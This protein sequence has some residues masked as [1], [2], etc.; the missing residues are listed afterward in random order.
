M[1]HALPQTRDVIPASIEV[2]PRQAVRSTELPGLFPPRT[3]TYLTDVGVDSVKDFVAAT[4]RIADLG[5]VPVPH[6]PARRIRSR[7]ELQTRIRAYAEEAGV[8]DVLVI[9]GGLDRPAGPY[10]SSMEILESGLLDRHGISEI[11]VAGHPEGSPEFSLATAEAALRLKRDFC[12][13]TG[14][15]MRIVTQFGFDADAYVDWAMAVRESGIGL[16]I[17]IGVAGP[18][19]ITTLIRYAALCGVGSSVTFLKK[20]TGALA[21]LAAHHSPESVVGPIEQHWRQTPESPIRQIHV[22]PFGGL[23]QSATW[24]R[25]R[26]SW[27][28]SVAERA[29]G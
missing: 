2:A 9:G 3:R 6:I 26:G 27:P 10:T 13:R 4:R 22:F 16:P 11:G 23:A 18:A 15:R 24:L 25:E 14:A 5:Y 12:E 21:A 17:H 8:T 29:L 1:S 20:R 28:G 19:S 7:D